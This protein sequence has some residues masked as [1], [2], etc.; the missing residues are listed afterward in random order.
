[1]WPTSKSKQAARGVITLDIVQAIHQRWFATPKEN[2]AALPLHRYLINEVGWIDRDGQP[3][4]GI[5]AVHGQQMRMLS[6]VKMKEM[7]R[8]DSTV[9]AEDNVSQCITT[10][11][12]LHTARTNQTD[13][14]FSIMAT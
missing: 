4:T 11:F 6:E 8:M 2:R 14:R 9:P 3:G 5:I 13:E 7:K 1:M 10:F 12:T